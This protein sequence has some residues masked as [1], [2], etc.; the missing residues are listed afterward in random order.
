MVLFIIILAV[1]YILGLFGF[2]QII[3]SIQ[4]ARARGFMT[5]I[6]IVSWVA[7]LFGGYYL[8]A[9]FFTSAKPLFIGY[10]VAF[11]SLL[12]KRMA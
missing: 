1:S 8:V 6:T 4:N 3:G 2:A 11:V 12:G 7:I 5:V 10:A 9:H